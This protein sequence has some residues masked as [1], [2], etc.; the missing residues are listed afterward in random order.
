MN[1]KNLRVR[2]S[3]EVASRVRDR[4]A[5]ECAGNNTIAALIAG[6]IDASAADRLELH[7]DACAACR[8]LVADLG[9]GL[10]ALD[11]DRLPRPGDRLGRYEIERVIGA[12]GMGVVFEARDTTLD[13]R[14]AVK[15]VRPDSADRH[16]LLAEARAMARLAHTNIASIYDVGTVHGQLYLCM[17]LVVGTTLRDW[18]E[19][20]R[21]PRE[22]IAMFS[23]A[24]RGL[25]YAHRCGLVH[26]DFKPDNVLVDRAGRA[27][28]TDFGVAALIGSARGIVAGT[29][30]FMAPEQRRGCAADARADQFAFCT[31]LG[32]ALGTR[33]PS[34]ARSII[35]RGRSEQ[36]DERFASMDA[37][38]G[39]LEVGMGRRKRVANAIALAGALALASFAITRPP[40][41]RLVERTIAR[42]SVMASEHFMIGHS[43]P[44]PTERAV[45]AVPVRESSPAIPSTLSSSDAHTA[46]LAFAH[47][48]DRSF[49]V[50]TSAEL[51]PSY[52]HP[53]PTHAETSCDDGSELT[54]TTERVACRAAP[55]SRSPTDAGR[56][57]TRQP[58]SQKGRRMSATMALRCAARSPGPPARSAWSRACAAGAGNAPTH[59]HVLHDRCCY[60]RPPSRSFTAATV[61][62]S[63]AKPRRAARSTAI[64][65]P[66]AV[67]LVR[68]KVRASARAPAR[69][70][71]AMDF[72]RSVKTTPRV[73]AIAAS[74]RAPVNARR[75]VATGSAKSPRIT[76]RVP[77]IA[78]S[79][80]RT[81]AAPRRLRAIADNTRRGCANR[82]RRVHCG[83]CAATDCPRPTRAG[84]TTVGPSGTRA[85]GAA[86][87]P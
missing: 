30:R 78:A 59:S 34:W 37:L 85:R 29:P 25:A 31:A 35:E 81:V 75:C 83:T 68:G 54:C 43:A 46:L 52:T 74:S 67:P 53:S 26:L 47:D 36:R 1:D 12:G 42:P 60:P 4:P 21:S 18:L 44:A 14:I 20:Q 9:R 56:A 80:N 77:P 24:G 5:V 58:A 27:V 63:P 22:I 13:R 41:T 10:S 84:A 23:A 64:S 57:W 73:Q 7:L 8:Q 69:R 40:V 87:S 86:S 50:T 2:N 79:S 51:A 3:V 76:R 16:T 82:P 6:A 55:R 45:D 72:A 65:N 61:R 38:L 19:G 62:A 39:A 48:T 28:V 49:A 15:V 66:M 33:A 11:E 17:E 70:P 71:A 32:E